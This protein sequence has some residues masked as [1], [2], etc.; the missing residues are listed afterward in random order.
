MGSP[1]R[2]HFNMYPE[3]YQSLKFKPGSPNRKHFNAAKHSEEGGRISEAESAAVEKSHSPIA[4]KRL[5]FSLAATHDKVEVAKP[6]D[7]AKSGEKRKKVNETDSIGISGRKWAFDQVTLPNRKSKSSCLHC[8][9]V[10][11]PRSGMTCH[12]EKNV[13]INA[14]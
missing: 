8:G 10:F 9:K 13:C 1:N 4:K 3:I 11:S 2:N 14:R 6:P 7:P 12:L 5:S